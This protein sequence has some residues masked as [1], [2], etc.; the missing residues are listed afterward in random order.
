MGWRVRASTHEATMKLTMKIPIL[1][2]CQYET[3]ID[4]PRRD[5][6]PSTLQRSGAGTRLLHPVS[7]PVDRRPSKGSRDSMGAAAVLAA[8]A[9]EIQ[10]FAR[11]R[12]VRRQVLWR[13]FHGALTF[14][15]SGHCA[16]QRSRLQLEGSLSSLKPLSTCH[17]R[18]TLHPVKFKRS[19]KAY[20]FYG[21]AI[22]DASGGPSKYLMTK[23]FS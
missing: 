6:A 9:D 11:V 4:T 20:L 12:F 7:R 3:R 5:D 22:G 10:H 1:I 13:A 2:H 17:R 15:L 16:H 18:P 23:V 8:K 19:P 14:Q 21:A